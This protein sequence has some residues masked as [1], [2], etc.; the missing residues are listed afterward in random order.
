MKTTCPRCN[1]DT[2]HTSTPGD[3]VKHGQEFAFVCNSCHHSFGASLQLA[4]GIPNGAQAFTDQ[5][6]TPSVILT[7]C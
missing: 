5:R 4:K 1:N 3:I 6:E 7:D 2:A